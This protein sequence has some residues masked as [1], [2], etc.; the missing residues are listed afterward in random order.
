MINIV[1]I[2]ECSVDILPYKNLYIETINRFIKVL[3]QIDNSIILTIATYNQREHFF[4]INQKIDTIQELTAEDFKPEYQACHYSCV[5][6]I[7]S[8]L[9]KFYKVNDL[10][11]PLTFILSH[12]A[13]QNS[14]ITDRLIAIQIAFLKATGWVFVFS[15]VLDS[16]IYMAQR[17]NYDLIYQYHNNSASL[18]NFIRHTEELLLNS[19]LTNRLDKMT[20][21]DDEKTL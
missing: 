4:C 6:N 7:C 2:V 3:Q 1:L 8:K 14:I 9:D 12:N 5:R 11:K 10:A 17:L 18:N 21:D 20:I 19:L 13:D 15:G 16:A